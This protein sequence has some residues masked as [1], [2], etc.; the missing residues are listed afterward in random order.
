M[1]DNMNK[2][3]NPVWGGMLKF[4]AGL[5]ILALVAGIIWINYQVLSYFW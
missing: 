3:P 1:S 5:G 4:L 2:Q